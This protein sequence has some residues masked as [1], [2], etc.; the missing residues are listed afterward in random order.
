MGNSL[1]R[2]KSCTHY[3]ECCKICR[4]KEEKHYYT[5]RKRYER[6]SRWACRGAEGKF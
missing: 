6:E 5:N 2:E 1:V 3:T 4:Q